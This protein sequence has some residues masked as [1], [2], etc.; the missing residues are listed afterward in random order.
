MEKLAEEEPADRSKNFKMYDLL[1]VLFAL[2]LF[3]VGQKS[4][5]RPI[6]VVTLLVYLQEYLNKFYQKF[7]QKFN[8]KFYQKTVEVYQKTVEVEVEEDNVKQKFY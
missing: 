1:V 3:W 4:E 5:T 6:A 2:G 7:C 8:Q